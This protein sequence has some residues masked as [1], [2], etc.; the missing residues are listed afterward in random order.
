MQLDETC[1]FCDADFEFDPEIAG[2][3][4]PNCDREWWIDTIWD[5]DMDGR[6]DDAAKLRRFRG[7]HNVGKKWYS[8]EWREWMETDDV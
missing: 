8:V 1:P 2:G 7:I 6:R 5:E 3:N 4:C